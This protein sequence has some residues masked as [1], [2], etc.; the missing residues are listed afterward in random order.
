MRGMYVC[1][2]L[3]LFRTGKWNITY[4]PTGIERSKSHFF[5]SFLSL[6]VLMKSGFS[7]GSVRRRFFFSVA[8]RFQRKS[9]NGEGRRPS[10]TRIF[11]V[12]TSIDSRLIDTTARHSPERF[13]QS[14]QNQRVLAHDHRIKQR[15]SRQ[16]MILFISEY[17]KE[18]P[19][20]R[21]PSGPMIPKIIDVLE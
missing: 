16:A 20:A 21:V 10:D 4:G 9:Q 12:F 15:D 11:N 19:Q 3:H 1:I 6:R 5:C 7:A 8:D 18:G 2:G 14:T 13:I 17:I